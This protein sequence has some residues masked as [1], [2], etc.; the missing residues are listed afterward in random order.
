MKKKTG[1]GGINR[2]GEMGIRI[3]RVIK[4]MG[5]NRKAKEQVV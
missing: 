5:N 2:K 3:L 4:I 1:G